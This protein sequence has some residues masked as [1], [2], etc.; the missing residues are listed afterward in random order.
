MKFATK[1]I[2]KGGEPDK[3][4][5]AIIPPIF[6][7]STYVQ[8]S[9]GNH[10]GFEYSRT[11][12]PTR[13][14]LEENLAS[15][16]KAKYA[17]VTASGLSLS[18]LIMHA[19]PTKSKIICG[20]DLYGGTYRL[21]STVFKDIH[22]FHYVDTTNTK[23]VEK[24]IKEV[25]PDAIW[26]ETPTNPLLK[27]TDLKKVCK[28]AKL[29]KVMSFVDNTFMSPYFQT[30]LELGADVVVHSMS[31]YIN[32]HSD[33]IGGSMMTNNK[34]FY[35]K[36]W[37]LQ[38]SIGPSQSPFDSWL[39]LRGVKTLALRM[40]QH[41]KNAL[42]IAKYLEGH[43][44]IEKVIYPG[45]KSHPQHSTAKKQMKGFGGVVSIYLKGEGYKKF[46]KKVKLFSLAESLG[47]VES[48]VGHPATMSHASMP[49]NLKERIGITQNLIRLSV[50]IEDTD[51]LIV[52]LENALNSIK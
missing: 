50:G 13:S 24:L 4:A 23:E 41:Q 1:V 44:K 8:N 2:H 34:S 19:L 12:N 6:Q 18:T 30:P 32:G 22:E 9:P 5:G 7:T 51:D 17:L 39:V 45:L 43:S 3:E 10:K 20:S 16:E 49:K 42:A 35:E 40:L 28:T 47:G 14:R 52:D 15:L 37:K 11:H 26:L 31:K 21:F 46:L 36:V 29:N 38:N 25:K 27:I 48:V 33:V